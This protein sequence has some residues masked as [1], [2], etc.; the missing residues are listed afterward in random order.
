MDQVDEGT[1]ISEVRYRFDALDPAKHYRLHLGFYQG[2]GVNR[3]QRAWID[4]LP[5]GSELTIVSGQRLNTTVQ[6]PASAYADGSITAAVR[7]TG[8]TVGALVSEIALEEETQLP[9]APCG[10]AETPTWTLAY[11]SVTIVGEPAPAGTI[12]TA[13]SSRGEVVGCF[14][15]EEAGQYGFMHIYGE[16]STR[17]PPIAG[18]RDEEYIIF[19]VNGAMA[20]PSAPL[21]WLDDK[22]P[23][24]VNLAA[25]I[26]EARSILLK[27]NQWSLASLNVE[28]PVPSI[29]VV[30]QSIA[31]KYCRVLG[32]TQVYDCLVPLEFRSLKEIHGAKGYYIRLD[33][34]ASSYLL[35]EG[36]PVDPATPIPLHAGLNWVGYLPGAAQPVA[37]ALASIAGKY[38]LVTDGALTYDPALPQYS[39]LKRMEPGKGYL[40]YATGDATLVYPASTAASLERRRRAKRFPMHR[41]ASVRAFRR[42]RGSPFSTAICCSMRRPLPRT[43]GSRL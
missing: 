39:T 1:G 41:Q 38:L 22:A 26:T 23:H 19:R 21:K 28:P 24:S 14:V 34:T 18:M 6:V 5:I 36:V 27:P 33:D 31:G 3:V 43:P 2:S 37:S 32:E 20:V 30:L 35:V 25:G 11:G 17:T 40:I 29:D 4:D 42:H 10:V 9:G 16:D 15:V 12:V 7:R 8:A 13:E